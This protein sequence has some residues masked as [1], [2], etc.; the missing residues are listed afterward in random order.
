MSTLVKVVAMAT[1]YKLL[2]VLNAEMTYAFQIVIVVLSIAS[3]TVGNIMALRQNNVKRM[4][5]FSGIS[6]A[7]FMLM[8]LLTLST[9]AG[10]LLYYASAY[11]LSG[12]AAFAVIIYVCRNNENE[13]IVNFH[14]L[15]KTNPLLAAVLTGSLLSMGGIP[16]FAGFFG[17]LFLF[18]QTIEAGYLYLVIIAV[19][20]SIIS[21]GYYFKL[22]LAM[23]G[24][25]PNEER[26][27]TPILY[28]GVAV[29]AIVLNIVIGF[30]PSLVMDLL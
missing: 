9:S 2:I 17:K 1:L 15:G 16:I 29:I 13:D 24:K 28:Y 21:I 22:I 8:T 5:A 30:F 12:I 19:I 14:G 20:N 10:T 23:Y 7:G 18:N 11:A 27:A 3:M 25:E 4:L 6:H 26:T